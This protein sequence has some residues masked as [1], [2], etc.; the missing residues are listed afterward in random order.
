MILIINLITIHFYTNKKK[1]FKLK[2]FII[3]Q[4]N[5]IK[6]YKLMYFKIV[7]HKILFS[8]IRKKRV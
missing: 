1:I 2:S 3:F 5:K 8:W 6:K 4:K 7:N